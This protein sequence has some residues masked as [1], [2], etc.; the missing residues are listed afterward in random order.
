M[1]AIERSLNNI[2]GAK[3]IHNADIPERTSRT[4]RQVDVLVEF[5]QG[6]RIIRIGIEVKNEKDPLDLPEI[7]Q[8]CAKLKKIDVDYR[9]VVSTS[10]FTKTA[11]EEACNEGVELRI[12][13]QIEKPYWWVPNIQLISS[14][15]S[16]MKHNLI[17]S[18]NDFEKVRSLGTIK[19]E[20]VDIEIPQCQKESLKQFIDR[21]AELIINSEKD[22]ILAGH[23]CFR[24][25]IN[26]SQPQVTIKHKGRE[27]PIPSEIHAVYSINRDVETI[28][29]SAYKDE[30]VGLEILT[31]VSK[32]MMK[33]INF[34]L[35][36]FK[37]GM[38]ISSSMNDISPKKQVVQKRK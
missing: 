16:L 29:M 15:L 13:S 38:K 7:E 24:F 2:E 10:G 9:C 28:P 37:D 6:S 11:Q 1:S 32:R 3:I 25:K 20:D 8:L 5:P 23:K 17:F 33:Q 36:P 12:L 4:L 35:T 22:V 18:Q 34:I 27:L 19:L 31:G 30:K 21:H 26:M 14:S